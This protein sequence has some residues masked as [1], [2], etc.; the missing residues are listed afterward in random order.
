MRPIPQHAPGDAG[1]RQDA[2]NFR[3]TAPL[4]IAALLR[5]LIRKHV[6]VTIATPSGASYTTMV[7]EIAPD[8]GLLRF[9]TDSEDVN[10]ERVLDSDDAMAVAYLDSVKVQ[11]DVQGLVL[12]HTATGETALNC[13]LPAE[14]FRFQRRQSFRVRP[15]LNTQP[16]ARFT[17]PEP[18]G[19]TLELR[20]IDV[21]IGGVALFLPDDAPAVPPGTRLDPARLELDADTQFD[22]GLQVLHFTSINPESRGVRL[23]CEIESITAMDLRAL[24]RFIDQ[25]QKRR[26]MME[27]GLA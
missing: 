18:P 1:A 2:S 13:M 22:C 27:R 25:T 10:L 9:S 4:E 26:R 19:K 23:G 8:K 3:V 11:F 17:L 20:V 14:V 6:L 12:V 21:S 5:E 7:W 24:Q 16:V 15:L